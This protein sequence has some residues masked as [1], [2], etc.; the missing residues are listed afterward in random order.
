[1]FSGRYLYRPGGPPPDPTHALGSRPSDGGRPPMTASLS[2]LRVIRVPPIF[3]DVLHEHPPLNVSDSAVCSPARS[4]PPSKPTLLDPAVVLTPKGPS[5][6]FAEKTRRFAPS[7]V[8]HAPPPA[9]RP[10]W[11]TRAGPPS[12]GAGLFVQLQK[13]VVFFLEKA[14]TGTHTFKFLALCVA[15]CDP[16]RFTGRSCS[17]QFTALRTTPPGRPLWR[18]GRSPFV[19][20]VPSTPD[21]TTHQVTAASTV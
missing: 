20:Q 19:G 21:R 6:R 17:R 7:F 18:R 10:V 16:I 11:A 12:A 9:T 2:A 13:E 8:C 1:M 3:S 14:V 15:F 5:R 4:L